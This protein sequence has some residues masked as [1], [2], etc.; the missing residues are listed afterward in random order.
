[1]LSICD[2]FKNVSAIKISYDVLHSFIDEYAR[3]QCCP[4]KGSLH[5][6]RSK[7][8]DDEPQRN[9][10]VT[11][12]LST[13]F[14]VIN[15]FTNY[16]YLYIMQIFMRFLFT[17]YRN[18]E[19]TNHMSDYRITYFSSLGWGLGNP[20]YLFIFHVLRITF[21]FFTNS[22]LSSCF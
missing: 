15:D 2:T 10:S 16:R 8:P 13:L 12:S 4:S 3:S 11:F 18:I 22:T 14:C 6:K 19:I 20:I 17:Y 1:M 5:K 7:V 21:T 9:R